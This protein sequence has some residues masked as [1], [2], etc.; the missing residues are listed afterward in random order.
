MHLLHL[1]KSTNRYVPRQTNQFIEWLV[2]KTIFL[3]H[4]KRVPTLLIHNVNNYT[5]N[6]KFLHHFVPGPRSA[7][8]TMCFHRPHHPKNMKDGQFKECKRVTRTFNFFTATPMDTQGDC[9]VAMTRQTYRSRTVGKPVLDNLQYQKSL[10]ADALR[11][12]IFS[13]RV[14]FSPSSSFTL[15]NKVKVSKWKQ[16]GCCITFTNSVLKNSSYFFHPRSPRFPHS[17]ISTSQESIERSLFHLGF[18]W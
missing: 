14:S 16:T 8:L 3:P 6:K 15:W 11:A 18:S 10:T 4:W 2:I 13:L 12:S 17:T 1:Q 9:Q 7:L 5:K